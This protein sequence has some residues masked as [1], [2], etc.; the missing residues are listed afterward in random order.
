MAQ[1]LEKDP[2]GA[3]FVNTYTGTGL[4]KVDYQGLLTA[5]LLAAVNRSKKE[6]R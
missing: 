2:L 3:K 4:R 1:D 5:L 6:R